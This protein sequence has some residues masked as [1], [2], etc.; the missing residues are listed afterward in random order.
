MS[1]T[2]APGTQIVDILGIYW[3]VIDIVVDYAFPLLLETSIFA[4]HSA[5]TMYMVYK[6]W[7]ERKTMP[8]VNPLLLATLAMFALFTAHWSIDAY[9][10]K[11]HA[12]LV[13]HTVVLAFDPQAK[14]LGHVKETQANASFARDILGVAI[15]ILGDCISL[16][17]SYVV[18]GRQRLLYRVSVLL[19]AAVFLAYVAITVFIFM[20]E[21]HYLLFYGQIITCVPNLFATIVIGYQAWVHWKDVRQFVQRS[22]MSHGL[23]VLTM[24]VESGVVY[25]V[26]VAS[27][28]AILGATHN[29][30][31]VAYYL[32]PLIALYPTIVIVLVT[33][34][35]TVLEQS[36]SF[37][38]SKK[39]RKNVRFTQP[40]RGHPHSAADR[41]SSDGTS[42][43]ASETAGILEETR[44]RTES[45]DG[46]SI[47]LGH[48]MLLP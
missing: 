42:S 15:L 31:T 16:W 24:V 33:T 4:F 41:S 5:L 1:D 43:Q 23:V 6:R 7:R 22:S 3:D 10:L 14:I 26:T 28:I 17:R 2:K 21:H 38:S 44:S 19:G 18:S 48:A 47:D 40:T 11:A 37:A 30:E 9:L 46:S 12:I 20:T 32:I 8:F 36:I 34:R 35:R 39:K 27:Y 13:S 29:T 45:S 25:V